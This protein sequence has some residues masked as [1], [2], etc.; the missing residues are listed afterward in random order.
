MLVTQGVGRGYGQE[1]KLI[2]EEKPLC[3]ADYFLFS[4]GLF[5]CLVF[6]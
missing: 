4:F 5:V 2:V 6:F 3:Q 1:A